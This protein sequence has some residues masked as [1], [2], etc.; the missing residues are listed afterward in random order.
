[1]AVVE[2]I[3]N[4]KKIYVSDERDPKE[5]G[6]AIRPQEDLE[7]TVE[8]DFVLDDENTSVDVFGDDNV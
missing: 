3:V 8:V 5:T 2:M 1:M 6:I 7:D 4:G